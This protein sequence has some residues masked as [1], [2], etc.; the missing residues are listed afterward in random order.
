MTKRSG[1]QFDIGVQAKSQH[2][3]FVEAGRD[4]GCDEDPAA[5]DNTLKKIASAPPPIS[6]GKRI[7]A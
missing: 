5:V 2:R 6:V 7:I 1:P 3:A 4:P